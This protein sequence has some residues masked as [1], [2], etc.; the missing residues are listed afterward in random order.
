LKGGV[1]ECSYGACPESGGTCAAD[2]TPACHPASPVPQFPHSSCPHP[3]NCVKMRVQTRNTEVEQGAEVAR[4]VCSQP[5]SLWRACG[6]T[7]DTSVPRAPG[8][9]R[10]SEDTYTAPWPTLPSTAGP[11]RVPWLQP[12]A[13]KP[14]RARCCAAAGHRGRHAALQQ[15]RLPLLRCFHPSAFPRHWG[16]GCCFAQPPSSSARSL[17]LSGNVQF[18]LS[19]W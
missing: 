7:S 17:L 14:C 1:A 16:T 18:S 9:G 13:A 8:L 6:G 4:G 19:V 10:L 2:A 15:H 5:L 3:C 12:T 11:Q